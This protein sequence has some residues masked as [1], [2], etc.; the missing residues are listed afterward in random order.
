MRKK[1]IAVIGP[2]P[3]DHIT[4]HT[5]QIIEKYGGVNN[6][7]IGIS[8]LLEDSG[9]VYPVSNIREQDRAP[10]E[11]ILKPY[12]NVQ[13]DFINSDQD[14]GDIISLTFLDQNK[15]EERQTGIMNP[16][17][18]DHVSQL[19][20]C[21]VFVCVP[22]TDFELPL[23]TL[24]YIKENSEGVIIFDAHGPTNTLTVHGERVMRFWADRDVWLPYIDV[25]KMNL[26]ESHACWF[27]KEYTQEELRTFD[28]A[29]TS[30]LPHL[31]RH[32]LDRGVQA[33]IVTLDN[34]GCVIYT[35]HNGELSEEF[36][37]SVK[38]ETV[39][40][41]TGCGDSFAGGIGFGLAQNKADIVMAVRYANALG[42]QRTQGSTFD[43]FKTKAETDAMIAENYS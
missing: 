3:R 36:V 12:S 20:H 32:V 16:I 25:L 2:I 31:A 1:N 41:T 43:V 6:P 30:H 40:D 17:V 9:T 37:P 23:E 39:V 27:K 13:L 24:R 5:G 42:A 26:E 35:L 33:L 15:R 18:P 19:L 28:H 8:K 10:I 14:M 29:G 11:E 21:D 38:V 22:I 7:V 4:T 34:R